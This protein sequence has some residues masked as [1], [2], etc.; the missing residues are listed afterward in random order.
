M[1][2]ASL[3]APAP[4]R[5][6]S[7][8]TVLVYSLF[9]GAKKRLTKQPPETAVVPA[10]ASAKKKD[11]APLLAPVPPATTTPSWRDPKVVAPAAV[12]T[13]A[14][15]I[16]AWALYD[17][18]K[19]RA[20]D[21]AALENAA[22]A[23]RQSLLD[24]ETLRLAVA[25]LE[26]RLEQ[27]DAIRLDL[28][29]RLAVAEA[30][31]AAARDDAKAR[32]DAKMK[33]SAAVAR[34][35]KRSAAPK[36]ALKPAGLASNIVRIER[37]D[38]KKTEKMAPVMPVRFELRGIPDVPPGHGV[39]V[40]GTWND[41]DLK[42]SI[43][44]ERVAHD[45]WASDAEIEAD[46]TYEYKY[47]IVRE[48][49][50]ANDPAFVE[51]SRWQH[52]NNRTLALQFSLAREVVL[53]EV[54]DAWSPDPKS[55]PIL[56]HHLNGEVEEIGSTQ[57]LRDCI[58]ELRREVGILT[59]VEAEAKA[60][61]SSEEKTSGGAPDDASSDDAT[62]FE[63]DP[64]VGE[65]MIVKKAKRR[66]APPGV[67]ENKV[68]APRGGLLTAS[69][70]S[71]ATEAAE[72]TRE[73]RRTQKDDG[74]KGAANGKNGGVKNGSSMPNATAMAFETA[75]LSTAEKK[76]RVAEHLRAEQKEAEIN[77]GPR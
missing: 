48:D 8:Q 24:G 55:S 33:V 62:T 39:A 60:A 57:L 9:A 43:R 41:W 25:D 10:P 65:T 23:M 74:V 17:R 50:D 1:G 75:A 32:R 30:T 27:A 67:V 21:E 52:G 66:A 19:L 12:A 14:A 13:A 49:V 6:T 77:P 34:S 71:E 4:A 31:L 44:M 18:E 45:R 70:S 20:L 35:R 61:A 47:V 53:V 72:R 76:A 28:E 5:A 64:V 37:D 40:C 15:A 3:A 29:T 42:D 63:L 36:M 56:L 38:E 73:E 69:P 46:D 16:A 7:D 59:R 58:R 22:K 26:S 68:A 2:A 54:E 51:G 11:P